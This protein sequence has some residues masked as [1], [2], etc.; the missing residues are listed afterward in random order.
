MEPVSTTSIMYLLTYFLGYY[1]GTEIYND[2]RARKHFNKLESDL[3]NIKYKLE[4][5]I[6]SKLNTMND[7]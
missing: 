2:Y 5:I 4:I 7:K 6:D 1:T 3:N